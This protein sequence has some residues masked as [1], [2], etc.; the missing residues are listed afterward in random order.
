MSKRSSRR[1]RGKRKE[2]CINSFNKQIMNT[3]N[4]SFFIKAC[5]KIEK[6]AKNGVNRL[7]I[8]S[9][10]PLPSKHVLKKIIDRYKCDISFSVYGKYKWFVIV[11]LVENGGKIYS[12]QL[13]KEVSL[14][15]IYSDEIY[16]DIEN[17]YK[18]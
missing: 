2:K 17:S 18:Y 12:E 11:Y 10:Q 4:N 15:Y 1:A 8:C 9:S 13:N 16:K 5:N 3:V 14:D 7:Y 6:A